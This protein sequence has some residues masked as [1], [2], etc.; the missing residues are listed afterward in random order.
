MLLWW[1]EMAKVRN[2]PTISLGQKEQSWGIWH[3]PVGERKKKVVSTQQAWQVSSYF[4]SL[5]ISVKQ[6]KKRARC[7]RS[8][9]RWAAP[10]ILSVD[11]REDH[12]VL[13]YEK[14]ASLVQ[15]FPRA[16]E[17]QAT[18]KQRRRGDYFQLTKVKPRTAQWLR[19]LSGW[20]PPLL[21][22]ATLYSLLPWYFSSL[23]G[24]SSP[25]HWPLKP[26]QM[27]LPVRSFY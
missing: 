9:E 14:C 26:V 8:M 3:E 13:P 12:A 6:H 4:R 21:R 1:K 5:G 18:A 17:T 19:S 27:S 22:G 2:V 15:S 24:S 16:T 10:A 25:C 7:T 11:S 23:L 20:A